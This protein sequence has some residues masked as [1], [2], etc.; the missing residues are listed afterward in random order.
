M[1][2][3]AAVQALT[4]TTAT[5]VN[6]AISNDTPPPPMPTPHATATAATNAITSAAQVHMHI[7][8]EH[9]QVI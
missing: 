9:I 3:A 2:N 4:A 8:I 5:I 1:A 6:S 7:L